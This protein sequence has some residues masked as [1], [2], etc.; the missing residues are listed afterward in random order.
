MYRLH[1]AELDKIENDDDRFNRLV[2]LNVVESCR[3]ILKTAAVQQS[4]QDNHYPIVHGWVFD[5]K[6]GHL[7]DLHV[8]FEEMLNG[9]KKIYN[10][11]SS[12]SG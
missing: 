1:E 6:D 11:P 5:L 7:K 12:K 10:L 9:I 3:N 8:D 4:Y 2:E